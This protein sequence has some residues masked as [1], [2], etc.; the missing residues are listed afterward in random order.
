MSQFILAL[1]QAQPDIDLLGGKAASLARLTAAGL[2]VPRGFVVSTAAY[3]RFVA[4]NALQPRI[5][6]AVSATSTNP[7]S[8]DRAATTIGQLFDG[9]AMPDDLGHEIDAAYAQLGDGHD[10]AVAVRSSATA[11]DLPEL[12]FAGQQETYL[13]IRGAEEL[14]RAVKRCWASLWTARAI[15]YRNN[16]RIVPDDVA[17][18]VAVQT[19]VEADAAGVMFTANPVSGAR[20]EVVV[21]AAWGLGEAIVSGLVTPDTLVLDKST[22]AI[23]HQDVASK[24]VMTVGTAS[25]TTE[26]PVPAAQQ[27]RPVLSASQAAELASAGVRI[28]QLYGQPM[29]VEWAF[30]GGTL[31]LLQARPITALPE[32]PAPP[33]EF[34]LPDPKG[35]YARSSVIEL[36][37]DPLS[38]LFATLGVPAWNRAMQ[39]LLTTVN[40]QGLMAEEMLITIN[41]YAYYDITTTVDALKLIRQIPALI[42]VLVRMFS[43]AQAR[44]EH[45]GRPHY[46]NLTARWGAQDLANTPAADMLEGAREIVQAAAD[47][48][49]TIQSGILPAAYMSEAA[50]TLVYERLIR[51]AGEPPALTFMLG[52]DSTP[53]RAEKSLYDLAEWARG[54]PELAAHLQ[55]T[56]AADLERDLERSDVVD[57][58]C[59]FHARFREHL[60]RYGHAVYDLDFAKP[61]PA[62]EPAPVLEALKFFVSGQAANP[63]V[64]QNTALHAR[65][66]AAREVR[67]RLR[68]PLLR[69]FDNF[70]ERAQLYA[71]LREDALADVGLGWPVLR[72]MLRELGRRLVAGGVL[73]APEDVF[74]LR[75]VELRFALDDATSDLRP[76]VDRRKKQWAL[77]RRAVPPSSLPLKGGATFMGYDFSRFMPAMTDQAPGDV[78]RGIGASPG[79]VTAPA[80]VIA[81]PEEFSRMQPHEVLVAKI[82][83]PAW[84]PLFALAS[85]VVTDVG[86][87]LSHSSIVAREYHIPAVLGTGVATE[88][89]A[90]TQKITVD[91]D[92]GTVLLKPASTNLLAAPE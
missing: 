67:A 81:G 75:L 79:Q 86:G 61:L 89:I 63:H 69:L 14:R 28:E 4:E 12:S 31:A 35:K 5:L 19:L 49:L 43:E 46:A 9:A 91:G 53:I 27:T 71:P 3:R 45:G 84:T 44:W 59:E 60:R 41:D 36:L 25:G 76:M 48:Y 33:L 70:L 40:L 56:S 34:R 8:L 23:K 1:D 78:I 72:R 82:T 22:G 88:R 55:R 51:R 80:R 65:E 13:N 77:E 85:G 52:F 39:A 64:R 18:A 87:P 37:P 26:Q 17:L 83:T 58:W 16:A 74:W 66:D 20:D 47:H 68:G 38:P 92:A 10:V 32:P 62:E 54:H 11:E 42:S 57:G 15:G 21:N 24:Q 30:R 90:N 2:A 50:F 7:A 29:D 6:Q 73:E